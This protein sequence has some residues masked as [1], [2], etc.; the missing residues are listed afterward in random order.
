MPSGSVRRS[1]A[2]PRSIAARRSRAERR[3][4][5][6]APNASARDFLERLGNDAPELRASLEGWDFRYTLDSPAPTVFD[7]FMDVW[8]A[9]VVRARFPERL[10]A[11]VQSQSSVAARLIERADPGLV[12]GRPPG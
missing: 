2:S 12:R 11:L 7:T 10:H 1:K 4:R 5:A 3:A 6:A 8:Q 9:R